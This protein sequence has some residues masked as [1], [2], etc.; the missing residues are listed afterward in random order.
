MEGNRLT[1]LMDEFRRLNEVY[2]EAENRF[3]RYSLLED[4]S[5]LIAGIDREIG[6]EEFAPA[7]HRHGTRQLNQ[8]L[9]NPSGALG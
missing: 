7:K 6:M 8:V 5:R 2:R 3:V 9:D 1:E 4:M